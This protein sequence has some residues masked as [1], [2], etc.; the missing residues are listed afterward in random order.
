M[1]SISWLMQSLEYLSDD[2]DLDVF[3]WFGLDAKRQ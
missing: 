3:S 2:G 1:Q